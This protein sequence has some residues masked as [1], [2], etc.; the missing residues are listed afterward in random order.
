MKRRGAKVNT[1]CTVKC[2]VCPLP[3]NPAARFTPQR[4]G[5]APICLSGYVEKPSSH[6]MK[7]TEK[8]VLIGS[9]GILADGLLIRIT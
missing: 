7:Q 3:R 1:V 5:I 2:A 6:I 4:N 8:R 9:R